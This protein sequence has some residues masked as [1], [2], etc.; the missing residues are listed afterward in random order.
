MPLE[1]CG[2]QNRM[3]ELL[4]AIALDDEDRLKE[5]RVA[6]K[7]GLD[8]DP[9]DSPLSLEQ[10]GN[11]SATWAAPLMR[12]CAAGRLAHVE[13]LLA[14]GAS[15]NVE[16][17]DVEG[18]EELPQRLGRGCVVHRT[19]LFLAFSA[20]STDVVKALLLAK[21][22]PLHLPLQA[23]LSEEDQATQT[24]AT[25]P[26]PAPAH[27]PNPHS[28]PEPEPEPEPPTLT[29]TLT[30]TLTRS[31]SGTGGGWENMRGEG[32]SPSRRG[33]IASEHGR[34]CLPREG[35]A[36]LS[37]CTRCGATPTPNLTPTPNPN[38][39]PNPNF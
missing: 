18:L 5:L 27:T 17:Q 39:N 12:A 24:P 25:T 3:E 9:A 32:P 8:A 1:Q 7:E 38:P 23:I 11:A 22:D 16:L 10:A 21:A 37:C 34:L 36:S 31:R 26:S 15:P 28:D 20:Q 30:L 29:L 4:R 35:R 2:P 19:P 14:A 33:V 6:Y 13:L